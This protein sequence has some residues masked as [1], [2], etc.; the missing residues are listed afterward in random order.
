MWGDF[1]FLLRLLVPDEASRLKADANWALA[2]YLFPTQG[3]AQNAW[4]SPFFEK[5][6]VIIVGADVRLDLIL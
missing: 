1:I 6:G 2:A 5:R 4:K 3:S